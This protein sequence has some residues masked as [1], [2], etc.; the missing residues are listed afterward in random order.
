M[1]KDQFYEKW[2][3]GASEYTWLHNK[4]SMFNDLDSVIHNA[5]MG[6]KDFVNRQAEISVDLDEWLRLESEAIQNRK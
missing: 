1:T 2:K 4:E 5:V 3:R 6:W